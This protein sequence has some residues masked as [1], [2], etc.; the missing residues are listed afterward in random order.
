MYS[1]LLQHCVYT[2]ILIVLFSLYYFT[3]AHFLSLT[4]SFEIL[5]LLLNFNHINPIYIGFLYSLVSFIFS[6]S[7]VKHFDLTCLAFCLFITT[8]LG[9]DWLPSLTND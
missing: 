4:L 6:L 3:L 5:L 9:H 7:S 2:V 8:I 1:Y